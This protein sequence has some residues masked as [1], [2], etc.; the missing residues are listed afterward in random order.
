MNTTC[1]NGLVFLSQMSDQL[2]GFFFNGESAFSAKA[3]IVSVNA[4]FFSGSTLLLP[5]TLTFLSLFLPISLNYH[6]QSFG[7]SLPCKKAQSLNFSERIW[8]F[9]GFIFGAE[10]GRRNS[11]FQFS[12]KRESQDFYA[13]N[14]FLEAV[15]SGF[16]EC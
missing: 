1:F 5:L 7:L 6:L 16:F 8:R 2:G 3:D 13:P 11:E 4:F 14:G 12:V 15:G 10:K 9:W